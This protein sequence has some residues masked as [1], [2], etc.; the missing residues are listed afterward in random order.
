[1]ETKQTHQ[2]NNIEELEKLAE[3][4]EVDTLLESL[5]FLA[6]YHERPASA[7]S[8][9]AGL[10]IHNEIMSPKMFT[11]S[12]KRIDLIVK[13]IKRD[14]KDISRLALPSVM[15]LGTNKSCILLDI[16]FEKNKALVMMPE[17]STGDIEISLDELG[18]LYNGYLMVIKPAYNFNNRIEREV[19]ISQPKKW[20]WGAMKRNKSIYTQVVFAALIINMFILATPMFTMNVYDRVLPNNA[21]ETL[22]VLAVGIMVVMVFDFILKLMRAHF[23]EVAG[24]RADIIMSSK[25]FDQLLNIRLDAKPASTGQFVSRLQSFE[26]VRDFFTSYLNCVFLFNLCINVS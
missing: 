2:V 13:T 26:S 3:T 14:I 23:I 5:L 17:I 9:T 22:W 18:K 16:D 12:A 11:Q 1:M 20:F 19:V 15:M 25:I 21:L 8:L 10:A 6:K 7:E 4:R 24:K